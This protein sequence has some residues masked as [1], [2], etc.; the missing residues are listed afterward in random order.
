MKHNRLP[1]RL[2]VQWHIIYRVSKYNYPRAMQM[3]AA[4]GAA[5]AEWEGSEGA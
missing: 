5:L 4:W 2:F 3:A 1:R